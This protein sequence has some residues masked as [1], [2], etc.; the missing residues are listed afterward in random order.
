[1]NRIQ[2]KLGFLRNPQFVFTLYVGVAI[3]GTL[4]KYLL[5][6]NVINGIEY[7]RYNNFLIFKH[8][9]NNLIAG[10][11]LYIHHPELFRDLFKYSPTFALL[12]AP[13]A[14][15][16]DLIGLLCWNLLNSLTLYFAISRLPLEGQNSRVYFHWFILIE[17]TTSI[18][19]FQSNALIAGLLIFAFCYLERRNVLLG[20]LCIILTVYIKLFGAVALILWLFYPEKGK[21]AAYSILW[22]M[23]LFLLP[24]I[25]VT[26]EQFMYLYQSWMNLL[27]NDYSSFFSLSIM[28]WL[29]SWFQIKWPRIA[30]IATGGIVLVMPLIRRGAYGDRQFRL[31]FLASLMLWMIVFNH[32]AESPTFIIAMCG[33]GVWYFAQENRPVHLILL[34]LAFFFTSLSVTDIVPKYIQDNFFD[35]YR[36]KGVPSIVIW[37]WCQYQLLVQKFPAMDSTGPNSGTPSSD[38]SR[39][40]G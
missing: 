10:K 37:F 16:P 5:E 31:L 34:L 30:V 18:Q 11:D 8:S 23:V 12:M 25:V 39:V 36:I 13:F 38:L 6:V 32:K 27:V 4:S 40:P 14:I 33:I 2:R 24:L 19:N 7:P 15:L 17:L 35:P 28:G 9:F 3:I 29:E 21:F 26:P 1:M 20:S 22:T